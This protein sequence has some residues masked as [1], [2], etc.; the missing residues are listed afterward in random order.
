MGLL[1]GSSERT[2]R[3]VLIVFVVISRVR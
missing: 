1:V 3:N 2:L